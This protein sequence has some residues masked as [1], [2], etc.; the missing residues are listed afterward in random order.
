MAEKTVIALE[1]ANMID[2]RNSV[3]VYE[4]DDQEVDIIGKKVPMLIVENHWNDR[5]FIVLTIGDKRYTV[6]AGDLEAA[7]TNATN[8]HRY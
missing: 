4:E 3:R 6:V 2:V 5:N 7:I 8:V 1:C